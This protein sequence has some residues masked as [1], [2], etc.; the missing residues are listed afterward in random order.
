MGLYTNQ[1]QIKLLI[2]AKNI[3]GGTGTFIEI[4]LK[5][6]KKYFFNLKIRLIVLEKNKLRNLNS[7]IDVYYYKSSYFY[8]KKYRTNFTTLI[9]LLREFFWLR[10]RIFQYQPNILLTIDT[11]CSL[12][13]WLNILFSFR[14]V[15][16]IITI[17]NNILDT[18]KAKTD[19]ILFFI[20]K[21]LISLAFNSTKNI[22]TVS[23][24]LSKDLKK[25]FKLNTTPKT[26]YY[27]VETPR[28]LNIKKSK[29]KIK[30]ITSMTRFVEQK[31]NET[32]IKAVFNILQLG[33]NVKLK[34][35]GE[36]PLKKKYKKLIKT[37][38]IKKY[39]SI[40]KWKKNPFKEIKKSDIIV[41]SSKREGLPFIILEALSLG[42]PVIAS[43]CLY[44]PKEILGDNRYGLIFPVG[45]D[46]SLSECIKR[47]ITDNYFYN[48][49]HKKALE[50]SSFFNI[51]KMMIAYK[52]VIHNL[53][54]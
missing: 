34:L 46:K 1:T 45:D 17:H 52:K 18:L 39:V 16:Q 3:E 24:E 23:K 6:I 51:D 38:K 44:G 33:L 54:Q 12:M 20:I 37:Y 5:E 40:L 49:M 35:V 13:V 50:R 4:F 47:L 10:S 14:K 11:H 22:I 48:Y 9:I 29:R 30:V 27:G 7:N 19:M 25:Q 32:L 41:L 53:L 28:F 26:I 15:K 8:P 42:K 43:D 21:K 31:D 36:G 2:V